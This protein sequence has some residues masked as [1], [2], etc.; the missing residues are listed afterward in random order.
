[1]TGG[2]LMTETLAKLREQALD[3]IH[4]AFTLTRFFRTRDQPS[5]ILTAYLDYAPPSGRRACT[6]LYVDKATLRVC[7]TFGEAR[8][9][10]RGVVG[11]ANAELLEF[12]GEEPVVKRQAVDE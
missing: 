2:G 4:P 7:E 1:M 12:L 3:C 5:N 10:V 11:L 9:Y 8:E 6:T